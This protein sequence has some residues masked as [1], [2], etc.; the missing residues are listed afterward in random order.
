MNEFVRRPS[1]R[2]DNRVYVPAAD[3]IKRSIRRSWT[4]S[5]P[6]SHPRPLI[7][8]RLSPE[9]R[10]YSS[11]P[12]R[13]SARVTASRAESPTPDSSPAES[14]VES[15]CK[16]VARPPLALPWSDMIEQR[17][18][19]AGQ[20]MSPS[21]S[22]SSR[23]RSPDTAAL[24]P[25]KDK[26]GKSKSSKGFKSNATKTN[27]P[28]QSSGG[29][30]LDMD[31]LGGTEFRKVAG[32][33]KR[34]EAKIGAIS[35]S[36]GRGGDTKTSQR[37]CSQT[38]SE[39][40]SSG[41]A[42][43]SAS[44][45]APSPAAAYLLDYA[46]DAGKIHPES[47][48]YKLVFISSDSSSKGS[49]SDV[50]FTYTDDCDWDYF[51]ACPAEKPE[52]AAP[53]PQATAAAHVP[54]EEQTELK[55]RNA[56]ATAQATSIL[57]TGSFAEH[58][59]YERSNYTQSY[60]NRHFAPDQLSLADFYFEHYWSGMYGGGNTEFLRW[61]GSSRHPCEN[62]GSDA[63]SLLQG[64]C[65]GTN[66]IPVPVP[67][68]V[69][70]PVPIPFGAEAD[71]AYLDNAIR[72]KIRSFQP[73]PPHILLQTSPFAINWQAILRN[74]NVSPQRQEV[75]K[76]QQQSVQCN[77]PIESAAAAAVT[78]GSV[79]SVKAVKQ[80]LPVRAAADM[81]TE[82]AMTT[83][84]SSSQQQEIKPPGTPSL[85]PSET[86]ADNKTLQCDSQCSD[87]VHTE[88]SSQ[89]DTSEIPK[90]DDSELEQECDS[91]DET[92]S[93]DEMQIAT[94]PCSDSESSCA[95]DSDAESEANFSQVF[96][97]NPENTDSNIA[98]PVSD[99][100]CYVDDSA[101]DGV[102]LKHMKH[103]GSS[104]E[105]LASRTELHI[106]ED[107]TS[108]EGANLI[109]QQQ[110]CDSDTPIDTSTALPQI[111]ATHTSDDESNS[112]LTDVQVNELQINSEKG[113]ELQTINNEVK[114]LQTNT[115]KLDEL[116]TSTDDVI[117][118][119][120]SS[121]EVN[122]LQTINDEVEELQTNTAKLDELQ[123]RTDDVIELQTR[124]EE[125]NDLQTINDEVEEL[126]T[127][128]AKLDELQTSTDDVIKLQ[129]SSEELNDLQTINDEIEELQTN[130][131]K[132]DEL[133]TRTDDVI[134]LQTSSEEVNDLQIINDE[135]EEL[136]TSTDVSNELQTNNENMDE[137]QSTDEVKKLETSTEKL[138][139][140]TE[141]ANELQTNSD[142]ACANNVTLE[143]ENKNDVTCGH[144]ATT[145]VAAALAESNKEE[146]SA[147]V[148][149]GS[150][151]DAQP[152]DIAADSS[153]NLHLEEALP[154]TPNTNN[155]KQVTNNLPLDLLITEIGDE[156]ETDLQLHIED[157]NCEQSN[158][159]TEI[160]DVSKTASLSPPD[161]SE[162]INAAKSQIESDIPHVICDDVE[163]KR[164][165]SSN[166]IENASRTCS[167]EENVAVPN[168]TLH[169]VEDEHDTRDKKDE[170][171]EEVDDLVPVCEELT[172][173][174]ATVGA[175][176]AT[177]AAVELAAGAVEPES[178]AE[179]PLRTSAGG[180][181][182]YVMITQEAAN[183]H[184][185]RN[186]K[187]CT[188]DERV[189][190][191]VIE[192]SE[193]E[194]KINHTNSGDE[195]T[196]S[197]LTGDSSSGLAG[198]FT[199]TLETGVQGSPNP[200]RKPEVKLNKKVQQAA[201]AVSALAAENVQAESVQI[202]TGEKTMSHAVL[203]L[204][205]GL[206]DDDSWVEEVDDVESSNLSESSGDEA[207]MD[208]EEELRGYHRAIDFTLHT[209]LEESC[210][211]SDDDACKP[212]TSAQ[213]KSE[214]KTE[215]EKY[216]F[217]G[218]GGS[219]HCTRKDDDD[220]ICSETQSESSVVSDILQDEDVCSDSKPA[221]S[222]ELASS[223]LEKYFLTSFLEPP[224]VDALSDNTDES[225][226]VGS[227][228]E[229][230]P[231]PE[232]R[233]KKLVRA[234]GAG[235]HSDRGPDSL[236]PSDVSGS[237]LPETNDDSTETDSYNDE[238]NIGLDG[239]DTVKRKKKKQP[240]RLSNS[241]PNIAVLVPSPPLQAAGAAAESGSEPEDGAKTPQ[242]DLPADP[243]PPSR[244]HHSRDSGFIGSCD[245]LLRTGPSGS[246]SGAG[247]GGSGSE[248]EV[249]AVVVPGEATPTAT[250]PAPPSSPVPPLPVEPPPCSVA[251]P[252]PV[253]LVQRVN[254]ARK[255]SFN[256]WS[257]D[258]E[259]NLMMCKMRA[260]FKTMVA[261]GNKNNVNNANNSANTSSNINCNP[262]PNGEAAPTAV[263]VKPPQ[264]VYFES[265]LTR[266]MK[267]VP[268]IKDEQVREIVEYLSSEDT[269]S[270]SYDSSDYTSSDLEGATFGP[271]TELQQQ[272]SASC[273]EIIQKFDSSS[274]AADTAESPQ[275]SRDDSFVYQ[276]LVA[277]LSRVA[278]NENSIP[279][280][281]SPVNNS[282]PLIAKVMHHIGSRLV[283]LMH[284][285]SAAGDP[286]A[287]LAS[288]SG[289]PSPKPRFRRLQRPQQSPTSSS[290]DESDS[291]GGSDNEGG[292]TGRMRRHPS[293]P[294]SKS[295]DLG[296]WQ[297]LLQD[298][299]RRAVPRESLR[300]SSSGVSDLAEEREDY[301]RFSWRGSFESALA[302]D[303][304]TKLS[305]E[306]KRRSTGSGS[307]SASDLF[308]SSDQL[309]RRGRVRSCGSIGSRA[310]LPGRGGT[311]LSAS[312]GDLLTA[313][314]SEGLLD[315]NTRRRGSVPDA[316]I[317]PR[318]TTLPRSNPAVSASTNSLPRLPL[319]ASPVVAAIHKSY[320]AQL[321]VSTPSTPPHQSPAHHTHHHHF[322]QNVKSARYRPPNFRPPSLGPPKRAVSAPGLHHTRR[323]E[324]RRGTPLD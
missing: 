20:H 270:D 129:T 70:V 40:E 8:S 179:T 25:I 168:M 127:N 248:R 114:E 101:S 314:D 178:V 264:L 81:G 171:Q 252:S 187:A 60:L 277:S 35:N 137:L 117:K 32:K 316:A 92:S 323:Q 82:V 303:S 3:L 16:T 207:Y 89:Q 213:I 265:E 196:P 176:I 144:I 180:Y 197:E 157:H 177:A 256:N 273:Q 165:V 14:L 242:P 161:S 263:K 79:T 91:G 131:A 295:H 93:G 63:A 69:P 233:R 288:S 150:R 188:E 313:A 59:N 195:L 90:H 228:S 76:K 22:S 13:T 116:Q 28:T 65:T 227:D 104:D 175:D 47:D 30:D 218:L 247:S 170:Q 250:S 212:S 99:V 160:N 254:L 17:R 23:E 87:M 274:L 147:E 275:H 107:E 74:E 123:T 299:E 324:R 44:S 121:E 37:S 298:A 272:I 279:T 276:R 223:R 108:S 204:E 194:V 231:S 312:G 118:L 128:T 211:E 184:N 267:T 145:T 113:N 103:V 72:I 169:I 163:G 53:P 141:N 162:I 219:L 142:E 257:S 4:I 135:V 61:P 140:N 77:K 155:N 109:E 322:L 302:A 229:G 262:L 310:S 205:E 253:P 159:E 98:T 85:A 289:A 9:M 58:A 245:D 134:K 36:P 315:A 50:E 246:S 29:E 57:G 255:D 49:N 158:V 280:V 291:P 41:V 136:Q 230:K 268:G 88:L 281:A 132:L 297:Q 172:C 86:A 133:Q 185:K 319:S 236:A 100:A 153:I 201:A 271:R 278:S 7:M 56:A 126:Q 294:R 217:F 31:M 80:E 120:T 54:E 148:S 66:L 138:E 71:L 68:P 111:N 143:E 164:A 216:F 149:T 39:E 5:N 51:E 46:L 181:T 182:S 110:S 33:N 261:G 249:E 152:A 225:G 125:V 186:K 290:V 52:V 156:K 95:D 64:L 174:L 269:W 45:P 84:M 287:L 304:R 106:S 18:R 206:A 307:G 105:A 67:Y 309:D 232:Q 48:D 317:T 284:E 27:S 318:S 130:T 115:A 24:A 124:S 234:R 220:D 75:D 102:Q 321:H 122:D 306:A 282:P 235:R 311:R 146:S 208:R 97:V 112:N 26:G 83:A 119:Q 266:L 1:R 308:S 189:N 260:F 43:G 244:K 10:A 183:P 221:D 78:K 173:L 55:T 296:Q 11:L 202:I 243:P 251:K 191:S 259:T 190:V 210:E 2:R 283:A 203:C 21:S 12:R 94:A 193:D 286:S 139:L 200:G 166:S 305:L 38:G 285:V 258:E 238:P 167:T 42:G 73:P 215:L 199:L 300:S 15:E 301:E 209:I 320:S 19:A 198:Y 6:Q 241:T 293:L 239:L 224:S 34:K 292:A 192:V 237:E 154:L 62:C 240:S 222:T 151:P 96:V 214:D 226:S